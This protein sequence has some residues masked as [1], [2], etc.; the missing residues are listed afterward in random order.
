MEEEE[1]LGPEAGL[2]S[3]VTINA[4]LCSGRCFD[5]T[6]AAVSNEI[7]LFDIGGVIGISIQELKGE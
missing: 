5:H 6:A 2:F 7:D 4:R 3:F 1:G